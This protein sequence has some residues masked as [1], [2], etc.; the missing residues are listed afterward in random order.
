M[1]E[2]LFSATVRWTLMFRVGTHDKAMKEM[3]CA[4]ELF[5]QELQVN[6]CEQYWKTPELWRCVADTRFDRMSIAELI[7]TPL[8]LASRIANGWHV[9]GPCLSN[10]GAFESFEGIFSRNGPGGLSSLDWAQ[11]QVIAS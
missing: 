8:L 11:F 9:I 2:P 4:E 10:D 7:S 3:R 5:G 6:T 1:T